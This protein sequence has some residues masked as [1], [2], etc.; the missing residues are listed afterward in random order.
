[1]DVAS[2]R[3]RTV[4][5]ARL[6]RGE[7]VRRVLG[8][9]GESFLQARRAAHRRTRHAHPSVLAAA[10]RRRRRLPRERRSRDGRPT[11]RPRPWIARDG[12]VR[13][14]GEHGRRS[15]GD[16]GVGGRAHGPI[17]T[18]RRERVTREVARADKRSTAQAVAAPRLSFPSLGHGSDSRSPLQLRMAQRFS[19]TAR[20]LGSVRPRR[21]RIDRAATCGKVREMGPKV[22]RR[23][24][25]PPTTRA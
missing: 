18:A 3:R 9:C 20:I 15:R 24:T 7:P 25:R 17:G 19:K 23:V 4:G 1:M 14:R 5:A 6:R 12:A 10:Q 16:S 11:P 8:K 13:A 21:P 22:T 2:D